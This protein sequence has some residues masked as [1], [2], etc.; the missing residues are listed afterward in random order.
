MNLVILIE[1]LRPFANLDIAHR[2]NEPDEAVVMALNDALFTLGDL[3]RARSLVDNFDIDAEWKAL[4]RHGDLIPAIRA[5][6]EA[7][8]SSLKDAKDA[9]DRHYVPRNRR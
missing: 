3:R 7:R 2:K 1:A 5:H 6:R 4:A 8:Q 9:V